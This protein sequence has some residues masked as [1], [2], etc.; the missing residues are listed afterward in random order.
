M[1]ELILCVFNS[2]A[3]LDK[4]KQALMTVSGFNWQK[5]HAFT[6][7]QDRMNTL[8][9]KGFYVLKW[10]RCLPNWGNVLAHHGHAACPCWADFVS[11]TCPFTES[12]QYMQFLSSDNSSHQ[13][14]IQMEFLS[15]A[16]HPDN[17]LTIAR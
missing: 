2:K 9:S 4:Y 3:N 17:C 11:D 10:A 7:P 8:E 14:T 13:Q 12:S 1:A 6:Y 16:N 5:P 15:S